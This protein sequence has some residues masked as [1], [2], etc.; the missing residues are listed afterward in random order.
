MICA[1][2]H[3]T[4]DRH[5]NTN[6]KAQTIPRE[7]SRLGSSEQLLKELGLPLPAPHEPFGAY[8]EATRTNT[9]GALLLS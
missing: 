2:L 6:S 5:M 8:T 9:R 4:E 1:R 3:Q 7:G